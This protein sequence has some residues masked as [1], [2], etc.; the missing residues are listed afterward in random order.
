MNSRPISPPAQRAP[1]YT[2]S[3]RVL[4]TGVPPE[5]RADLLRLLR[6]PDRVARNMALVLIF[7]DR[8]SNRRAP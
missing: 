6:S 3:E 5:H 4:L 8:D 2:R 1:A 7:L